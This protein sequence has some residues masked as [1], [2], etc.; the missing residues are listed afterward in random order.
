[1]TPKIKQ[2]IVNS[3]EQFQ[4]KLKS[5]LEAAKNGKISKGDLGKYAVSDLAELIRYSDLIRSGQFRKAQI[6]Q[7][8]MDTSVYEVIPNFL[9]EKIEYLE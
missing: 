9:W 8:N 6:L 7:T 4:S 3:A 2:K 5:I 1:M